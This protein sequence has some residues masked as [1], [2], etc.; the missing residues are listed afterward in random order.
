[1]TPFAAPAG[2]PVPLAPETSAPAVRVRD[3][4][5]SAGSIPLVHDVS[6][7][8]G[9]GQRVGIIGASG[10]GKTLTCMAVAGLL[11]PELAATGSVRV[12]GFGPDVLTASERELATMRGRL[13]GVVF[14]EPMT[15]LNPTMRVDRQIMEAMRL[16][17]GRAPRALDRAAA[18]AILREVGISDPR[19]IARS[20][21]HE[22]SGGQ[23]QRVVIA[24]ALANRPRLLICDEPTTALDVTVQATVLQL[25]DAQTSAAGSALLFISHDLAVVASVCDELLVMWQGTI[26]ERGPVTTVLE[27]PTHP[28]T[29]QLLADAD[30]SLRTESARPGSGVP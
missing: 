7:D 4:S 1:M 10:S 9:A 23:R 6:F 12:D 5:I 25:I 3:L 26:V 28:H 29:R 20:F 14:Q 16:H 15:A 21:P 13:T 2:R 17:G 27:N 30:V 24:I 11:P 22:L 8:V 18:E 19:R